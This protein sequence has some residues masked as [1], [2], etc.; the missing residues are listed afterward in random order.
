[1]S[2]LKLGIALAA[3]V[4]LLGSCD[5]SK[6]DYSEDYQ[7][8]SR[9]VLLDRMDDRTS[10]EHFYRIS[11]LKKFEGKRMR[12]TL[13]E[14][15]I[16]LDSCAY[17]QVDLEREQFVS[18]QEIYDSIGILY[19]NPDAFSGMIR[20]EYRVVFDDVS[21]LEEIRNKKN[22]TI[23]GTARSFFSDEFEETVRTKFG[24]NLRWN[25]GIKA[26]IWLDDCEIIPQ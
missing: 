13:N 1:M 2:K 19:I 17:Y 21:K 14:F 20:K 10:M 25:K 5:E 24:G 9:E 23:E 18:T 12:F 7:E 4:L 8:F 16:I 26:H 15:P 3:V 22:I 11:F 6:D